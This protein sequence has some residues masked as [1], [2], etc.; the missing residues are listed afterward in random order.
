[1]LGVNKAG[2]KTFRHSGEGHTQVIR[3]RFERSAQ[4]PPSKYVNP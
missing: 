1:M 4:P 2:A 3:G